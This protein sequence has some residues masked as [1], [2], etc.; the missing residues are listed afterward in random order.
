MIGW[1][2]LGSGNPTNGIWYSNT[3]TNDCG[4]N[5]DGKGN[6]RGY[7][8]SPN[9]GWLNF[10]NNGAPA[11]DLLTGNLSGSIWVPNIGWISLSNAQAFVQTDSISPGADTNG[12]GIPDAWELQKVGSLGLLTANGHYGG[13]SMT[14]YQQYLAD[15]DPNNP[16]DLLTL[17]AI[18]ATGPIAQVTWKSKP[19]RVYR[20]QK[21]GSPTNQAA[22]ADSGLGTQQP[23]PTA[24]TTRQFADPGTQ[25]CY[26]VS[27]MLPLSP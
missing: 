21:T 11:V 7:A 14:D 4:V 2:N 25:R 6:L 22:W 26:R 20:I 10:E 19:T 3:G 16:A 18:A 8:W 5:N 23:D 9:V 1:I 24:T 17:T 12:N 15:T 27:A 13:K